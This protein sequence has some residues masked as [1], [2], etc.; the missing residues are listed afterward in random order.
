MSKGR[1][2]RELQEEVN[3]LKR[4]NTKL[5]EEIKR[6]KNMP[7]ELGQV[8]KIKYNKQDG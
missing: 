4:E 6:L 3:M 1:R 5:K 7:V 8:A 2:L